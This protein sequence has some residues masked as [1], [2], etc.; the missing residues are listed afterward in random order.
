MAAPI[1]GPST[2]GPDGWRQAEDWARSRGAPSFFVDNARRYWTLGAVIGIR[3]EVAYGHHAK[4]TAFGRF[5]GV[6]DESFHNPAGIK[7]AAG[8]G[9]YDPNAHE[10][11]ADWDQ[12]VRAH[13]NH[14]A[15]YCGV[16]P[17]GTPHGRYRVVLTTAHAGKVQHVEGLNGRWAPSK[18]YG[19]DLVRLY[20]TPLLE[21]HAAPT[22]PPE[23]TDGELLNLIAQRFA[24]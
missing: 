22:P 2:L 23:L 21:H 16:P 10:R 24:R 15:A 12:G 11:F 1:L 13:L 20:L 6:L 19:D 17:L 8:G 9:D 7:V 14:L 3:P 5:G 18:T 4:E